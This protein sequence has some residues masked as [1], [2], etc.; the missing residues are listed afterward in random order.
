MQ[1]T[2]PFAKQMCEALDL[3]PKNV[4]SIHIAVTSSDVVRVSVQMNPKLDQFGLM[5]RVLKS[6]ELVDK[7][8]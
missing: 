8:L 3:D 7:D 4:E 5:T 6:Y 1:S 2:H